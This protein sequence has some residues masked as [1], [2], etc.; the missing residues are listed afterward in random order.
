MYADS[1][2]TYTP[3]LPNG[4]S[5][6][7]NQI[8]ENLCLKG[9]KGSRDNLKPVYN[10]QSVSLS[11]LSIV[12]NIEN[13]SSS[14]NLNHGNKTKILPL[15]DISKSTSY[16]ADIL[17]SLGVLGDILPN[18]DDP[19]NPIDL[20]KTNGTE[21]IFLT[22]KITTTFNNPITIPFNIFANI[23]QDYGTFI[24]PVHTD[25]AYYWEQ[26]DGPKIYLDRKSTRL[27]SSHR[28]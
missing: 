3:R 21:Y 19:D 15:A 4:D 12:T 17:I 14:I 24:N 10:N 9:L 18:E 23:E 8:T 11:K 22:N 28:T 20:Y 16:K 26:L 2:I 6:Y 25:C 27:N 1:T 5:L 13:T 7:V